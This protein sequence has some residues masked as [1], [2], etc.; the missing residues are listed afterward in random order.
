[1][2]IAEIGDRNRSP[3]IIPKIPYPMVAISTLIN[4]RSNSALAS[5][6]PQA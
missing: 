3:S 2:E 4:V 1:M 5:D 6:V